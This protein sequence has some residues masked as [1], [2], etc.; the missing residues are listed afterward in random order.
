MDLPER[1]TQTVYG[2]LPT[3][4]SAGTFAQCGPSMKKVARVRREMA[5]YTPDEIVAC[6]VRP[7][8]TVT[9]TCGIWR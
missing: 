5:T 8:R 1:A 3:A 2:P 4:L 6:C 7:T 9:G